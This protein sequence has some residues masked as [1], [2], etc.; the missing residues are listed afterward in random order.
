MAD[1]GAPYRLY[2][3]VDI[4]TDTFTVSWLAPGGTPARP[5][6]FDQAPQGDAALHQQ[7]QRSAVVSSPTLPG[8]G[9]SIRDSNNNSMRP[10]LSWRLD[11]RI[12]YLLASSR[13]ISWQS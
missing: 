6:T 13:A 3:G 12:P 9:A 10:R 5:L 11:K 8:C 2:V 1:T 7:L 4:A